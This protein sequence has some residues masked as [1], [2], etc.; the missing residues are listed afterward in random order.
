MSAIP[1]VHFIKQAGKTFRLPHSSDPTDT[2]K[3]R[4]HSNARTSGAPWYVSCILSTS[5][6]QSNPGQPYA[7]ARQR[8]KG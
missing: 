8:L 5:T 1:Y 6:Q 2:R 3:Y 4:I 7:G